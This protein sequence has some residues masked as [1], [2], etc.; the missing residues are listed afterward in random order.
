MSAETSNW[1]NDSNKHYTISKISPVNNC[2][3]KVFFSSIVLLN[4]ETYIKESHFQNKQIPS[5]HATKLYILFCELKFEVTSLPNNG[6][7]VN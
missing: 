2:K 4:E 1:A 5:I 7:G 6:L 3:E